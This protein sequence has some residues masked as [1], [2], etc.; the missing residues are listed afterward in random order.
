MRYVACCS[1]VVEIFR[2]AAC[3]T[4]CDLSMGSWHGLRASAGG[5]WTAGVGCSE[6]SMEEKKPSCVA[7]TAQR[8]GGAIFVE[9]PRE[10]ECLD[11][12]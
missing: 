12:K 1:S 6:I 5:Y 7:A 9:R 3:M 8:G 11:K 4:P 2:R 10:E